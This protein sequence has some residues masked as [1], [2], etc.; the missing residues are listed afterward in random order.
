M[1]HCKG[2][3]MAL[4]NKNWELLESMNLAASALKNAEVAAAYCGYTSLADMLDGMQKELG[5]YLDASKI[6]PNKERGA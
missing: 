6:A 5:A 1:S 2:A 3:R 4:K